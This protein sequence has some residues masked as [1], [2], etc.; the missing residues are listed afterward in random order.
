MEWKN[1]KENN[2]K[3]EERKYTFTKGNIRKITFII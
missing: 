1:K 2:H 3:K